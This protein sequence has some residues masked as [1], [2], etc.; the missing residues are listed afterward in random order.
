MEVFS[1]LKYWRTTSGSPAETNLR[2]TPPNTNTNT[3]PTT[4][5]RHVADETDDD[6]DDGP[7][8]DLEFTVPADDVGE[9]E[10]DASESEIEDEGEENESMDF[11]VDSSG[12]TGNRTDPNLTLS[13]SDDLF[14]KG[15][16]VPLES[17]ELS[18]LNSS[19]DSAH[20]NNNKLQFP[21][22]FLKPATKLRV[23]MLGFK[24]KPKSEKIEPTKK[25]FTV[26]FKVEEVPIVSLFTRDNSSRNSNNKIKSEEVVVSS[27]EKKVVSR[28]SLH[29]YL[30]MVK[31]LN[32]RVSKGFSES[33]EGNLTAGL[34]NVRKH[35]GKSRSASSAVAAVPSSSMATQSRRHDDSLLQQ[36]DG[37]QSAILH[38][39]RSFTASRE[40]DSSALSRCA[41][42]PSHEK[43]KVANSSRTSLDE[44]RVKI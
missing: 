28:D 40:S 4:T 29:K 11:T 26:K 3:N 42:D 10:C 35:L 18:G 33:K 41:S 13:P 30:K 39:K 38:C 34:R 1:L 32:F 23:L 7:F 31:Q 12:S 8:F 44:S 17:S 24:N 25:S 36:Q 43:S 9:Q 21:G 37:I 6:D 2:S 5:I 16:F 14:F 22:S 15:R 19:T 27:E 20:S